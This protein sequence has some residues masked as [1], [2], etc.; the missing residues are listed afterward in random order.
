MMRVGYMRTLQNEDMYALKDGM[1]V[2]RLYAE[3]QHHLEQQT[4]NNKL[5]AQRRNPSGFSEKELN[6]ASFSKTTVPLALLKT[7]RWKFTASVLLK[8]ASD[9]GYTLTPLITK[10]LINFI[11]HRAGDANVPIARGVA[12][13]FGQSL[14]TLVSGI[15]VN[16]FVNLAMGC[17]LECKAILTKALLEKSFRLDAKSKQK[18]SNGK[19]SS[20]L[21]GDLSRIDM[22]IS[23]QP[24]LVVIPVPIILSVILLITNIGVAALVGIGVFL[25]VTCI[26]SYIASLSVGI[27]QKASKHTD[28]RVSLIS[29]LLT[30]M[31]MVKYY[32][33]ETPYHENIK[34]HRDK[35]SRLTMYLHFITSVFFALTV[36]LPVLCPLFSFLTMHRISPLEL[37]RKSVV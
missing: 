15:A 19:I 29:E 8:L 5:K 26:I 24:I 6:D 21:G 18:F 13:S 30:S 28:Q 4:A 17:G 9:V 37:G 33:W 34:A 27:R 14:L 20:L 23:F 3:F 10:R 7:I 35:E 32:C 25:V 31:K 36:A 2:D 11:S 16:H 1:K 12:Y 22:A